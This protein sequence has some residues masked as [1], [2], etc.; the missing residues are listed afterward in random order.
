M[1]GPNNLRNQYVPQVCPHIVASGIATI[2]NGQTEK[3]VALPEALA[4]AAANYVV[5]VTPVTNTVGDHRVAK[6]DTN[7]VMTGFTVTGAGAG[8]FMWLVAT[9]GYGLDA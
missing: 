8:E 7:G 4:K 6:T 1:K 3:A 9:I 5:M 2:A